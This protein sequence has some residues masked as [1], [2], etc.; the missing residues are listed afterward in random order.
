MI[1]GFVCIIST[2]IM[3]R[4]VK[5]Y[6]GLV[7]ID[8]PF[9]LDVS[10]QILHIFTFLFLSCILLSNE[11]MFFRLLSFYSL[12]KTLVCIVELFKDILYFFGFYDDEI[13]EDDDEENSKN[14][15]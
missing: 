1:I 11:F 15:K 7:E 3:S 4:L 13:E 8:I 6:S 12:Y 5:Y 14:E 2:I 10:I 9:V